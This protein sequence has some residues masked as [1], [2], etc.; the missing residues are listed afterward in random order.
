MSK[1]GS[2]NLKV[3][4]SKQDTEN[5]VSKREPF[6][7]KS[8]LR[9]SKPKDAKRLLSRLI[10]QFQTGEITSRDAKDLAY[11]VS[12]FISIVKDIELEERI[13]KLEEVI[14]SQ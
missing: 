14:D 9:V 5:Q 1:R 11:L 3:I 10:Y 7:G 4:N 8:P 2:G 6:K 13:Q 12:V